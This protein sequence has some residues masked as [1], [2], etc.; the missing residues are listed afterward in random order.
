MGNTLIYDNS[1]KAYIV[2]TM[3]YDCV[4][5]T[6]MNEEVLIQLLP[7]F[8]LSLNKNCITILNV[9]YLISLDWLVSATTKSR[10]V[11]LEYHKRLKLEVLLE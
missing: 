6:Q 1:Y 10:S 5:K 3:S 4:R 9:D 11:Y 8:I 7:V 2:T